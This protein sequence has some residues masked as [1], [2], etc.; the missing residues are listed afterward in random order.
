MYFSEFLLCN[1]LTSLLEP[2]FEEYLDTAEQLANNPNIIP[3]I[4]PHGEI[5]KQFLQFSNTKHYTPIGEKLI[6]TNDW[7]HLDEMVKHDVFETG[8]HAM[9]NTYLSKYF[10]SL[11]NWYRS[12]DIIEGFP[13]YLGYLTN[14][15][16]YFN[17]VIITQS[18]HVSK[19]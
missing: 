17:E 7:N 2:D 8:S 16:W 1:L 3:I 10:E 14:K 15:K 13:K 11:G 12:K 19:W 6:V 4:T 9:V 5:M 18:L